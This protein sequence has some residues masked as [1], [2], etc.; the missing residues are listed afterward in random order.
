MAFGNTAKVLYGA[1]AIAMGN[2]AQVNGASGNAADNSMALGTGAT[3]APGAVSAIAQGTGAKV[4]GANSVALGSSSQAQDVGAVALGNSSTAKVAG[5][6]ALGSNATANNQ[7]DVALGYGSTTAAANPVSGVNINGNTYSFNGNTPGSVVSVGSL[8]N[9]RQI[10]NVAAGQINPNSTDAINGSQLAATNQAVTTTN[11][12]V[13]TLG[14]NTASALGGGASYSG[15]TGAISAPSYAIGGA[16][17]NNVGAALAAIDSG[18]AGV[19]QRTSTTD[20]TTLVAAG[21]TASSPGIAQKL[22][23]LA[24]GTIGSSSTD[25]VNGSQLYALGNS[26]TTVLGGNAAYDPSTG[27]VTMSNV[28]GTGQT[29]VNDAI[30]SVNATAGKGWNLTASGAN[31]TN[32]PP[33]A[34]VDLKNTDGNIVVSKTGANNDVNFD[35]AQNLTA[36]N[37]KTGNSKLDTNGLTVNDGTNS[38]TYRANG[39]SIAN[40]PSVMVSGINAGGQKITNVAAGDVSSVS[41]D[42]VNGSQLYALGNSATTVLGGNAAYDPSTGQVAMSNVGGTGQNNVSDAIA[43]VNATAGKGWNLTASGANGTNVA[44]GASVDLKNTDGNI[45]VSKIGANNDVNFDLAK[46]LTATSVTTGDSKLDTNGL[47]VNDG[48]N[49]TTYGADGFSIANGPS[50]TV[51]GIKAGGQKITNVAA[52]DVSSVSTDAVNG[53]QLYATNQS[54]ANINNGSTGVVQR[55]SST[56]VTTLVAA[57]GTASSPG[58]AQKL[59]NL[60]AGTIGS[61]STD[62]ANGSQL[63]ALGNSATTVLGGNAAYDPSTGQ[64]TM[65]NVGGTG[66]NNVNDAIASVNATAGKGWNLQANGDTA[67][68]V[69]PGD[70]VQLKD[71][72]NIKVTRN[73]TDVT[74]ATADDLTA[75]SITTGNSKLDTNGLT[76]TGG[77]SVLASGIDAGG[78]KIANVADGDISASSKDAVNGSQLYTTNQNLSTVASNSS[79]YLGGGANVANGTAPTYNLDG[80]SYNNVGDALAAVDGTASKGWNLQTNGDTATQVKPGDVVQLK[81]GQN[82]KITRNGADVTIAAADDL[83]TTSVATGNSK[84]DTNGLRVND[85]T[86]STIYGANGFSIANGPSVTV[87]GINAGGRKV[88]NVAAGEVSSSSTDAVIGSQLYATNQS[89]ANIN[90]GSTGVVQRTS[91]TDVTALVA[92]RGTASSPGTAQKLTNLAAGTLSSSSTDAVNGSQLYEL[93][94]STTTV[95]GGNA[96]FDPST[97]QATM[98]NVGGTGKNNVNDAIASVND[99]AGKGWNLQANGDTAS[100]VAPGDTVQFKDGQNIKVTRN[101]SDVTIATADDLTATSITAGNSKLDT[102]GLRVNDGTNSTIYGANGFSIANGPSVTVSGINAGGQKITNVAA[103]EVSSTSTDAVIGSQLYATNQS[104]ANI[105]SGSTG[106]VQRTG[107]TDVTALVAAGGTAS[108]PGTAQKLTNLAAGTLSSSSTDAVNGSQLHTTNQNLATVASNAST[109]L[110][111]GADVANG[112]APTYNVSGGSYSNVGAALAAVDSTANKGWN[113]QANG[114]TATQVKPGDAVQFKDGR[115]VKVTR[116]GSDVTIAT[117]DDLTATSV[118]TGNSKLDT[119]GLTVNNG[120]NSTIYGANGFSIA[121]GPSVTASGIDAGG[122]KITNVAAGEVSS[123]STDAVNGSQLYAVSQNVS[124]LQTD[125]LLWNTSLGAYDAS[126][127]SGLAQKITNVAAGA[128]SSSSTDAI[129][130]AQFFASNRSIANNFGGGSTVNPDGTISAPSY[131]IQ[132]S[133]YNNVGSAFGAVDS[134][135]TTLNTQIANISNGGGVKYVHTNSSLA[136]SQAIGTDSVAVGPAAVASGTNSVATGNNAQATATNA[137][138]T[139]ANSTAG[140]AGAVALGAN[141]TASNA[142]DVALGSGSTTDKAVQTSTMVV[143]GTSYD[144]AGTATATVSVGS[145]GAER[146]ITNVAAGQVDATSTDAINGSQLYAT[147]EAITSL[148]SQVTTIGAATQ[149][150]VQYDTNADGTRKNSFTLQGGDASAPVLLSNVAA[151]VADTDA[152]N[153]KQLKDTSARTLSSANTYTDTKT[154]AAIATANTYT[155]TK[156]AQTLLAANTYTDSKFGQLSGQIDGVRTEARQAAAIGLAAASLRYDDRPGKLSAA[157]GGGVWRGQG[158]AA[159]GLGYTSEDQTMR[160][161]ISA[162]TADGQWGAGA[163]LSYTFN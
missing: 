58:T 8:G 115:N 5:A 22:T 63:Y 24:A 152:V 74:I 66:Q 93:G 124:T 132:G 75:T 9:E 139:G 25:A 81:D 46:N 60:A 13:N 130:G 138:S 114:D 156:S 70:A 106:V 12:H 142:G 14:Q 36:T 118:N 155:D 17:Y 103:G 1:G 47:T 163:G 35:L 99:T 37:V 77:P 87:S 136:D 31:G 38:T 40:G 150:T 145:K 18:S 123:A 49:L 41:T 134:N 56:D 52:G 100:K 71:G 54:I 29:N 53:S 121:N 62:A 133:T 43:S 28:G 131:T 140:A 105:N 162:T 57:G 83:T 153:V 82:I 85:G 51:S 65:S 122:Q 111:G 59:T 160:V 69:K 109:Y 161:N 98:S 110:G 125:A 116:N 117:A 102:N 157:V 67:T 94:N 144:V 3:V 61:S 26:V 91:S 50:V 119:N 42:A 135:L 127:G 107:T 79:T 19:V 104:I 44:P 128:V 148:V 15:S 149:N 4:T 30:A 72:H 10:T 154:Q 64:V 147:N 146:T 141:A 126:H 6:I 27:Q 143:N 89:I 34:S 101:G 32:V 39:F 7:N 120:T 76:I 21:G 90:S 48:T 158:A 129:N 78:Q 96:A 80:G 113:L 33:G 151:G 92:A 16:T 23:N 95:L 88:T 137:I 108:S 97:G 2:G 73:G 11:D 86:N 55:T 68:Q 20:V 45:V 84:L 112:T 159:F